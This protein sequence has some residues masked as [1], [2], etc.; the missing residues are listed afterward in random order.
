MK[1]AEH[2][3]RLAYNTEE[4]ADL[5]GIHPW[6]VRHLIRT[7]RLRARNTGKRYIV[8]RQVVD[9]Y[10]SGSD[11]PIAQSTGRAS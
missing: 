5:L 1:A 9:E 11:N 3:E 2:G 4:V 6:Q 7:G 8:S 10:L